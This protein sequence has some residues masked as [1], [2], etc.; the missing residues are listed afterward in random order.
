MRNSL[1]AELV[2]Q[3]APTL[4]GLKAASLFRF[5]FPFDVN[6]GCQVE[7]LSSIL[8]AKNLDI[9]LIQYDLVKH[10]GL[11]FVHRPQALETILADNRNRDFF[12]RQDYSGSTWQ[13][14]LAEI[15]FRLAQRD[16]FPHEIGVLLGY[17]LEDVEAYMA[18]PG[19]KGLCSGCW[20]AYTNPA[21]ARHFFEK[22]Q[23]C[24]RIY[25]QCHAAGT[26][27]MQLAVA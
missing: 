4:A 18:A 1:E 21:R 17:P 10:S 20:K 8:R 15:S 14:I 27:L 13:D 7:A 9:E 11:L 23:K 16:S 26:S 3:C 22:C 5:V 12:R 2:R 19:E 25:C 6:P 24:T